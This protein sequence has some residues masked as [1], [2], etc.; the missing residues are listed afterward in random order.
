M[1]QDL[2]LFLLFEHH[3][4]G[5]R[6]FLVSGITAHPVRSDALPSFSSLLSSWLVQRKGNTV[7]QGKPKHV[8]WNVITQIHLCCQLLICSAECLHA[9]R[10][11]VYYFGT[12]TLQT[13]SYKHWWIMRATPRLQRSARWTRTLQCCCWFKNC[14]WTS[15]L[16]SHRRWSGAV[17]CLSKASYNN[18]STLTDITLQHTIKTLSATWDAELSYFAV[19]LIW[20]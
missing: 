8:K 18:R 7:N 11:T 17:W 16:R 13:S 9:K 14:T 3:H 15:V 10:A 2:H 5:K 6:R 20:I 1:C 12:T 4:W 19:K